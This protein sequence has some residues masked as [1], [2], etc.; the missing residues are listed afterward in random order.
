[1]QSFLLC[2]HQYLLAHAKDSET[3]FL[4]SIDF[5]QIENVASITA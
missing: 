3:A 2:A 4:K 1:M 5:S